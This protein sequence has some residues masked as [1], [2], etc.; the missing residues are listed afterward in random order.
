MNLLNKVA[1]KLALRIANLE[2]EKAE[3]QV[4]LA[5]EKEVTKQL[6]KQIEEQQPK[7]NE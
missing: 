7:D 6:Q 1:E 3:L 4:L 5:Q 2:F